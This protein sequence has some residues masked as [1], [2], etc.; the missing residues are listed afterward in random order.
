MHKVR[1]LGIGLL[2][3]TVIVIGLS[4]IPAGAATAVTVTPNAALVDG[5][6][7]TVAASVFTANAQ[8]ALIECKPGATS[9]ADCDTS[10][11]AFT[12]ADS[13]GSVSLSYGVFRQIF[14]ANNPAGIDCAPANCILTVAN[15]VT[16]TEAASTTLHFDAT[17]PLPPTLQVSATV[18]PNGS[19]TKAGNVV[20]TGT[21]TCNLPA[22]VTLDIQATERAGRKLFHAQGFTD[23]ACN[24]PTNYAI[25]ATAIDGVFRGGSATVTLNFDSF[26]TRRDVFG[27]VTQTVRLHA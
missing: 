2:V 9:E 14:P 25:T 1:F 8:L 19:F 27:T 22:T 10:T 18:N 11:L 20:V 7:V 16:Q 24:G 6:N 21:V 4:A 15:I 12:N 26:T 13:A 3:A 5:Q 17:V 23:I